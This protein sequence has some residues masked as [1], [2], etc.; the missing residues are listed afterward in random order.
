[1]K[2][3]L[4]LLMT[5]VVIW[6]LWSAHFEPFMLFLAAV[7]IGLSLWIS[8]RMHIVDEEGA[9]VQMGIRPFT[10]FTLWLA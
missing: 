5:L 6:L 8:L 1:M 3:A 4:T 9:T 2:Y 7:S 10:H